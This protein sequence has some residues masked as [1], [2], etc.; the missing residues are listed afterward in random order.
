MPFV[1]AME[2]LRYTA[3]DQ[4]N[5]MY[6]KAVADSKGPNVFENVRWRFHQED[7]LY[8]YLYLFIF[9]CL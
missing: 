2:N 7:I 3:L 8:V 6:V 9:I 1:Q 5:Y 4:K